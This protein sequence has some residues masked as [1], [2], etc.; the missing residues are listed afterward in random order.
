M[1]LIGNQMVYSWNYSLISLITIWLHILIKA[2]ELIDCNRDV[3]NSNEALPGGG[4]GSHVTRLGLVFIN[5]C[6]LLSALPSLSQ[7]GRGRLS[8]VAISFYALSL[9][10]GPSLVGIYLGRASVIALKH[11]Q[12]RPQVICCEKSNFQLLSCLRTLATFF[13]ATTGLPAKWRLRS[14]HRNS[15]LLTCHYPNLGSASGWSKFP[16]FHDQSEH[17]DQGSDTS[18]A[19][20]VC[21]CF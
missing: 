14:K 6:R 2:G 12:K 19:W 16:T 17:P 9:L 5:A 21:A 13:N 1:I 4:G 10:F 15:M 7:F 20:N 18:L 3:T 8:L 11:P